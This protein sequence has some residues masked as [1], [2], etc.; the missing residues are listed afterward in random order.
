MLICIQRSDPTETGRADAMRE[1]DRPGSLTIEDVAHL[2]GVSVSS[3][4]NYLSRPE[5]LSTPTHASIKAAVAHTDYRPRGSP[6]GL[7]RRQLRD[8]TAIPDGEWTT[9]VDMA[10]SRRSIGQVHVEPTPGL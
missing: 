3:A 2:A 4:R 6:T 1:A 8:W 5:L 9:R 10:P 7:S